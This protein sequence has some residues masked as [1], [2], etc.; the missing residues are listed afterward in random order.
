MAENIILDKSYAFAKEIVLYCLEVQTT[1]REYVLSRQL[2]RSETSIGAN[3]EEAIGG[4]SKKDFRYKMS[5]A[6]KES[7]ESTYWLRLL[8]DTEIGEVERAKQ[9]LKELEEISRILFKIV[10]NSK[11]ES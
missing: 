8:R 3:V 9:L 1:K 2:L 5:I 4:F 11:T 10:K 7:R 6:Y